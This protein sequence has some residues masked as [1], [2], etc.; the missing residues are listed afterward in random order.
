MDAASGAAAPRRRSGRPRVQPEGPSAYVD[1]APWTGQRFAVAAANPLATEAGYQMLHAGGSAVD[2][3]VAVQMVLGLVEPQ[4]SGIGGGAFLL[5]FDGRRVEAFDGRETAPA[6]VDGQLFMGPDGRPLPFMQAIVGGRAVGVPGVVRMLEMAHR[7]HGRL[8][9]RSLFEPAIALAERGFAIS[10]RLHA[11]LVAEDHLQRDPVARAYFHDAQGQPWPIGHVLRN[12]EYAAVLRLVAA[13]GS[14]GLHEGEVAQAIVD[15]VRSHP[16]NPG[17]MALAD[18]SAYKAR[19]REPLCVDYRVRRAA[20]AI[21]A[22]D[23]DYRICGMPPPSS[24]GIAVAQILGMLEN[25]P[26]AALGLHDGLPQAQWLHLYTEAA[27]LAFADRALYVGDPDYV[28]SPAAGWHSLVAPAYLAERARLI[29]AQ[30]MKTAPAGQPGGQRSSLAPMP[31]QPEYG[32]SHISIVDGSGR[33]LAMTT[34]IEDAWGA[35]Q[36]VRGF[37]LNNQLSDF[38]FEPADAQGRPV[39][40]RVEPGKRPRS[41]MAPTLVFDKRSGELLMTAGSP[42]GPVIIHFVAKTLYGMLNW[43]LAPQQ[44]VSLPNFAVIDGPLMLEQ[45]R[46]PADTR[47]A[48]QVRGHTVRETPMPS[49]L[50]AIRRTPAGLLGGA[51]PRREGLVMGE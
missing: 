44:A 5:H 18:L 48:L 11:L 2:A 22:D 38:S 15:K 40:N 41:S 39:A 27:R 43:G 51:D 4:S 12:P 31:E 14:R 8:P 25:T 1:K 13:R 42:G 20:A 37:L 9:W 50:Q 29:G 30:R 3:A 23:R 21:S 28:R 45:K 47:Q 32:T 16:G 33:A 35:R 24:G 36:M 10:P 49:G 6:A 26:A 7:Q 17:R 46:F 19:K 34:S